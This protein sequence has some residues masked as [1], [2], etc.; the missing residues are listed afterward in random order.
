MRPWSAFR[1]KAPR[2]TEPSITDSYLMVTLPQL[3]Q[4]SLSK[5]S[6]IT[7]TECS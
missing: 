4:I 3:S 2:R 6:D 5:P 7:E 1:E